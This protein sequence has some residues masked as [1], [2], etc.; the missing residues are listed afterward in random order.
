MTNPGCKLE[1]TRIAMTDSIELKRWNERYATEDYHFG[2]EPNVFLAAQRDLL[3][4]GQKAL[5]IADGEGRNGVWLARQGLEVTSI[6]FSPLGVEKARKLA[7]HFQ[8]RIQIECA[9]LGT[10]D[11]GLP[12]FDVVVGI[13][14]QFAPPKFR[15]LIFRRM[16]EVLKVGGLILLEGYRPE[17]LKYGT[18]G[19]SDVANLYTAQLLRE[20]FAD[21]RI[22]WLDEYDAEIAEGCRHRGMSALIDLAAQKLP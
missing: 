1:S 18:G 3:K 11:W 20:A 10:W 17:Q 5:T 15:D 6:D 7:A 8:V 13:F 19:P 22:L 9:D 12:R 16:K 2:I 4:P 14:F 21:M